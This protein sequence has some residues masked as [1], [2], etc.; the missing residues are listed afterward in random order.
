M[1]KYADKKRSDVEKYK[2]GDLVMLSTKDLKYQIIG[3][4]T[5][6]L[7][8]RFVGPY[9]VKEIISSNAVKLELPSTVKIH[10]VVNVS[11]IRRYIG[12]VEGQKKEQ[13]APVII[14]GEKEWEVER[15][16]NKRKV[17]GKDKYLVRWKGFTAESDTWEGRE[18]LENAKEAIEEFEKEYWQDMKD[19]VWQEREETTFKHGELP[20][21]FTAKTL[22]GWSDKWYDQEYW[23]K[24]ERNWRRWKGKKP[25]RRGTMKTIPKEEEIQEENS[26][27]R[28]WT[29]EDEDE[30]GNMVDPYYEL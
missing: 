6:K 5:E 26:G 12:Q 7:T 16:L 2:V 17:R 10:P 9:K 29:E 14:E 11:R 23:G 19:V 13:P 4:R 20:G 30:M 18:N 3:R 27:V 25:A 28:E 1:K 21:R 24:L 15:I 22:Y 8:E